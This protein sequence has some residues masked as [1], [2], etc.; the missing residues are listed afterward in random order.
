[1]ES[2]IHKATTMSTAEEGNDLYLC[3]VNIDMER[4]DIHDVM[5]KQD[6]NRMYSNIYTSKVSD[7]QKLSK[8]LIQDERQQCT[9]RYETHQEIK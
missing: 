6:V 5:N 1:M 2:W 8:H 3:R 7:K 9:Q 4:Q